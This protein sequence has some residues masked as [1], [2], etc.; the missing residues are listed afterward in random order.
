LTDAESLE[1]GIGPV[2]S[3][4][5]YNPEHQPTDDMVLD[6]LGLV[7]V[8]GLPDNIVDGFLQLVNN[9][10]VN[11]RKGCNLLIYWAS[12]NYDNREEVF[13]C[14]AIIRTLG[15]TELADKLEIDRTA[16]R[17]VDT[18]TEW[19]VYVGTKYK[20]EKDMG[21]VQGATKDENSKVGSKVKWTI[22]YA[23]KDHFLAVL[24]LHYGRE[25]ACGDNPTGAKERVWTIA[26]TYWRNVLAFRHRTAQPTSIPAPSTGTTGAGSGFVP[27][28]V[29][30]NLNGQGLLEV[31]T[32][33]DSGFVAALKNAVP[34]RDRA[35]DTVNKH[36]RVKAKH[37]VTVAGLIGQFYGQY[38]A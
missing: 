24:G 26:K 29:C 33:Y 16:A 27:G 1:H 9:D 3:K 2:C 23:E 28:E 19:V 38:L 12:C 17:M 21:F 34:Y 14:S 36:W 37:F 4:K 32:P 31:I 25:L 22:P 8:S 35:W 20:F 5:Y 30:V 15:Y 13:R 7:A 10:K 11:A 18:G 6:A